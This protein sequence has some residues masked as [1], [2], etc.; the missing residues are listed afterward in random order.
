MLFLLQLGH[1]PGCSAG[2]RW[3][4]MR[5]DGRTIRR[6]RTIMPTRGVLF[7]QPLDRIARWV[8][9]PLSCFAARPKTRLSFKLLPDQHQVAAKVELIKPN[10]GSQSPHVL[11]GQRPVTH[12]RQDGEEPARGFHLAVWS[13]EC[14]PCGFG[15]DEVIN[16]RLSFCYCSLPALWVLSHQ[17]IGVHVCRET[18]DRDVGVNLLLEMYDTF[19][20]SPATARRALGSSRNRY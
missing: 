20:F 16:Q 7:S 15:L 13:L 4:V 3:L 5:S 14:Q 19:G 9:L 8:I 1:K 18:G 10:T 17:L 6:A 2:R 12:L 11:I